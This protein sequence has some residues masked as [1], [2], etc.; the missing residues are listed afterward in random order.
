[1][2]DTLKELIFGRKAVD[3]S[4]EAK[5]IRKVVM[6]MVDPFIRAVEAYEKEDDKSLVY[7]NEF[8]KEYIN[9]QRIMKNKSDYKRYKLA[10][11]KII[12]FG[13]S[14]DMVI[15]IRVFNKLARQLVNVSEYYKLRRFKK[16]DDLFDDFLTGFENMVE[17]LN[18]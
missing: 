15:Y 8:I 9:L 4:V 10:L 18:K 13:K 7:F 14:E 11:E 1:M 16:G 2:F 17:R 12:R 3:T 5:R 6:G